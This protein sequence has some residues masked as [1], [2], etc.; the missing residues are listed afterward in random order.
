MNRLFSE[1]K[2]DFLDNLDV[3]EG[4]RNLYD[5]LLNLFCKWVVNKGKNIKELKRSD[6]LEYKSYLINSDKS[7]NTIN[8]YLNAIRTFYEFA[9]QRGEHENIAAGIKIRHKNKGFRKGHL[10]IEEITKLYKSIDK[11]TLTGKRNYAIINLMLRSGMRCVELSRLRIC[12][13]DIR[14]NGCYLLIQRKGDDIRQDKIGLTLKAITPVMDY[15]SDRGVSDDKEYVFVTNCSIGE[16]QMSPNCIG[17]I[18]KEYMI[19]ADIY[20]K[21]KTAHSL[22]H[23]SAVMAILNHVPIKEVQVMLGHKNIQTTEIYLKS[24]EDDLRLNNP[25]AR[26]LDDMF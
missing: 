24:I 9:E 13:I 21:T 17:R 26:A 4:T 1:L 12:D 14:K 5:R 8:S 2:K 7:E 10:T 16:M 6:I 11:D 15:L 19:K 23:T 18:V 22:R 3:K 25:A 20:D